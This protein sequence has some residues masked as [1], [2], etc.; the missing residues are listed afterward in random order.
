MSKFLGEQYE[1]IISGVQEFGIFVELDNGIEGLVRLDDL[2]S[3]EYEYDEFSLTLHGKHNHFSIGDVVEVVVANTNTKLHQIDFTL[4][5]VEPN[6]NN[7]V[8]KKN[9]DKNSKNIK[10]TNHCFCSD[11]DYP[12]VLCP[13]ARDR[14]LTEGGVGR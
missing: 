9:K 10:K 8:V 5:G 12:D 14:Y 2:P 13:I 4:A 3:D 7:F 11:V 1:G 6:N